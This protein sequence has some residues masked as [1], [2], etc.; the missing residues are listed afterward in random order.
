MADRAGSDPEI[1]RRNRATSCQAEFYPAEFFAKIQV[2]WNDDSGL[3]ALLQVGNFSRAPTPF[4]SP[5]VQFA[6]SDERKGNRFSF[7]VG[8]VE[9][10]PSVPLFIQI[11]KNVGV[12]KNCIHGQIV[13]IVLNF[14]EQR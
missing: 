5:K 3:D 9:L 7:Y 1:I 13:G 4:D 11:G 10:S 12:E 6:H 2:V 8:P 14:L